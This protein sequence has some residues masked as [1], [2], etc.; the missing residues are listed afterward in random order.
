M[1]FPQQKLFSLGENPRGFSDR[2]LE[3]KTLGFAE[4]ARAVVGSFGASRPLQGTG[5][6]ELFTAAGSEGGADLRT[7]IS[8][9]KN[10][11]CQT[12]A[13]R[14]RAERHRVENPTGRSLDREHSTGAGPISREF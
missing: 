13:G 5:G 7:K 3:R 6:Y 9:T 10:A 14:R 1:Y 8:V 11:D 12:A 4:K 2:D